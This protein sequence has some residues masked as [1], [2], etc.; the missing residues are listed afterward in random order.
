MIKQQEVYTSPLTEVLVV[1]FEGAL[2]DASSNFY[3]NP[4][5]AGGE[6]GSGDIF[7]L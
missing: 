3:G 2:L 5:E 1:R 6:I 4:G 7:N